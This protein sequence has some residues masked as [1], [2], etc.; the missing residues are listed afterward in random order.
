MLLPKS[1]GPLQMVLHPCVGKHRLALLKNKNIWGHGYIICLYKKDQKIRLYSP[2]DWP[3]QSSCN[4]SQQSD[5]AAM[6][7][8][9]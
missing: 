8:I 2:G 4:S 9:T 1:K 6:S 3:S 5:I 7:K